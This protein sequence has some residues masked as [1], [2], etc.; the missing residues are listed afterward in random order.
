MGDFYECMID[1]SL[2][3]SFTY[4]KKSAKCFIQITGRIF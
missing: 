3:N 1:D 4:G 2:M